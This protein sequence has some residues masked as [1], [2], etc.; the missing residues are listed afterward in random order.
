MPR[1]QKFVTFYDEF[2]VSLSCEVRSYRGGENVSVVA[3]KDSTGACLCEACIYV[4]VRGA[5]QPTARAT[6][7]G[8][9]LLTTANTN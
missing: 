9:C 6:V 5:G 1:R 4:P 7:A 3:V 8:S 2:K